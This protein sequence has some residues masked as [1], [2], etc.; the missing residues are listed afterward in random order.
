MDIKI[1]DLK[2]GS[3]IKFVGCETCEGKKVC[4][5]CKKSVKKEGK[6]VNLWFDFAIPTVDVEVKGSKDLLELTQEDYL[7]R[8]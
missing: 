1:Q 4:F 8:Q 5:F 3:K 6:V 7:Q 2:I